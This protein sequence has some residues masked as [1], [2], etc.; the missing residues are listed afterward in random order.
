M[1]VISGIMRGIEIGRKIY[2][3]QRRVDRRLQGV[4]PA[5]QFINRYSPPGYRPILKKAYRYGEIG[6]GGKLIYDL[7]SQGMKSEDNGIQKKQRP[8]SQYRETRTNFYKSR[9]G[10]RGRNKFYPCPSRRRKF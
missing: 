2:A 6:L 3:I 10:Q 5:N 8:T 4:S 7:I 9:S 1:A